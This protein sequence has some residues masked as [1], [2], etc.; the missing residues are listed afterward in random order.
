M[1]DFSLIKQKFTDLKC[2]VIIPTYNNDRT[3]EKVIE[4]VLKFTDNLIIVN[5]GSTDNT[6][7]IIGKF[8]SLHVVNILKNRGKGLALKK[9]FDVAIEK[10]FRYAITIDSDGQHFPADL[11]LFLDKIEQEP[12]SVIIGARNMEQSSVPGTSNFGHKFSIFW[13]KVETGLKIDDVQSGFRLYPLRFLKDMRLYTRKYEFEVEVLVRLAWRGVK[14]LSVPVNVYYPSKED[15]VSHFRK[16]HDFTRVSIV[17][18]ILVFMA[19]LLVRP[20]LFTKS[21]KKKSF[22]G[23]I[24]EYVLDSN[25][26]N[27]KLALSVAFGLFVGLTPFW[28]WQLIIAFG[29][30]YLFKLNKFVTVATSNI[31]IPPILPFLLILSYFTGGLVLG[32]DTKLSYGSGINLAWIKHNLLQY[33]VGS[34]IL[35]TI[36]AVVMGLLTFILLEVFRKKRPVQVKRSDSIPEK[37]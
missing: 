27:T 35:G 25:D 15:R 20:F 6:P 28:G 33:V 31:S 32:L 21:L 8:P 5:D 24:K 2:C 18:S 19:L 29:V 37:S 11:N 7:Q 34:F 10:G 12:D 17:N 13:F 23:F 30:A 9:G 1:Q 3:L 4:D 22:K 26:S 16:V 14:V 36:V